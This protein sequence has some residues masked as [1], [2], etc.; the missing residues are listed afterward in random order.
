MLSTI[1]SMVTYSLHC[2]KNFLNRCEKEKKCR[3]KNIKMSSF[4]TENGMEGI[5]VVH[6]QDGAGVAS[7]C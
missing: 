1:E 2:S 6:L 4:S 5:R 7:K 3:E